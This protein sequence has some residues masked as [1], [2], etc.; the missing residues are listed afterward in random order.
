MVARY[1]LV[2]F[3]NRGT[4]LTPQVQEARYGPE[5]WRRDPDL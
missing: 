3:V 2:T 1:P 4:S 5:L